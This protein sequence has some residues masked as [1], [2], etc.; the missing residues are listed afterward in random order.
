MT[1]EAG[2]DWHLFAGDDSAVPAS[3]AM[4]ES[5]SDPGRAIVILEVDGADDQQQAFFGDGTEIP[6]HWLHRAGADPAPAA[7]LVAALES[8]DLPDGART[9]LSGRG[10]RGGG[11]HAGGAA[12]ARPDTRADLGQAILAL[13]PGQR[14]PRGARAGVAR[15]RDQ[16]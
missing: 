9:R 14:P 3:L 11:G 2:A 13:R 7:H 15:A 16:S 10:A 12:R 5:L 1:V 6:V 4:A 8:V